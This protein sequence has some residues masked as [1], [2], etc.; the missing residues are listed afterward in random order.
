[1]TPFSRIV[2]QA[3]F[4][5]AI[6]LLP[7]CSAGN[8]APAVSGGTPTQSPAPPS[9]GFQSAFIYTGVGTRVSFTD[10]SAGG[11][12]GWAW[13]FGDGATSNL[14][15]PVHS[16]SAAGSYQVTL[17][18]SCPSGPAAPASQTLAVTPV[19][20][21]APMA[22]F[23]FASS[24]PAIGQSVTFMDESSNQPTSWAWNFGDGSTSTLANPAHAYGAAGTYTVTL[25]AGNAAGA[26]SASQAVTAV[27]AAGTVPAASFS[28]LPSAPVIGQP[29]TFTD[30]SSG[31][32]TSWSWQL[33]DTSLDNTSSSRNPQHIFRA[34]GT[35]SVTLTAANAAG[36]GAPST[37]SVIVSASST[38]PVPGFLVAPAAPAAGQLVALTDAS[39]GGATAWSWQF[40]DD[41][42]T[43]S[44]PSPFH[45]FAQPGTYAV[46]LTAAN[47]L[48]SA[49]TS[50]QVTVGAALPA[51]SNPYNMALT[52]SDGAQ[53]TT[54]AFDGRAMVTG[55]REAQSFF[56]PGK[57]ADY[58]GFQYLRDNTPNGLGHN[59][60]FMTYAANNILYILNDA[61]LAQLKAL[62]VAQQNDI[63]A[64]GLQRYSLMKA[65]RRLIDGDLPAGASGLNQ[66]A[67]AL[68]SSRLY[69]IDGQIAFDR[70][71][72]YSSIYASMAGGTPCNSDPGTTQLACL[73]AMK[74]GFSSW[75]VLTDAQV[76]SINARMSGLENGVVVA[77]MTYAGDILSW[78][79]GNLDADVYFC[80]ERHGTYYGGFYVKDGP[81]VGV[82]GYQ[83]S[84]TLTATA[85][86]ALS[87]PAQNDV[88]ATQAASMDTLVDLQRD[89]L[90]AGSSNIVQLRTGIATL[91]RSLRTS[92]SSAT[93]IRDRVLALSAIYGQLDGQDNWNYATV[94]AQV[95]STLSS[96][97]KDQLAALRQSLLSGRYQDGTP[98]DFTTC[99]TFYLYSG[100]IMDTSQLYPLIAD[101]D[102][103]FFEP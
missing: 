81:A 86:L 40:A 54:L 74:A 52:L 29:V 88:T 13:T 101:T 65:F 99:T 80:P 25:T 93:L 46:T 49:S 62:A 73:D 51:D 57:V 41:G 91:L 75:P 32:P 69:L 42:S 102:Y 34:A 95:W 50:Q 18:A 1:M 48:G 17:A 96:A 27:A 19:P 78:Y 10:T 97:Q 35:Y 67:V 103:L 3:S 68:A 20:A 37:R 100:N 36:S 66:D 76:A 38:R 84:T 5:A 39:T 16:Y 85:G 12:N 43:S 14:Q 22:A 58:T 11:P 55:N 30:A 45:V 28:V 60:D 33:G 53:Q 61:Q 2:F 79:V 47:G 63:N 44:D 94:F 98:F 83:I 24:A 26:N 7:G 9:S 4:L 87:D 90:Y 23:T 82:P 92:T 70:A 59:T 64:Y 72:L 6:L 56:P 71:S 21:T 77:M 31:S 89:N 8:S 15:N